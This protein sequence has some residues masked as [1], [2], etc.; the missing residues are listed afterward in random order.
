MMTE[1][2]LIERDQ[3]RDLGAELLEVTGICPANESRTTRCRA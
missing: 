1:K 2:E 3:K